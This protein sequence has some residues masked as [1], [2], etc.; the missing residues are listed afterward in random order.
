MTGYKESLATVTT[1]DALIFF[2]PD[3]W[4]KNEVCQSFRFITVLFSL[5]ILWQVSLKY[6]KLIEGLGKYCILHFF[7]TA[8]L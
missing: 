2:H 1:G 6:Q 4:F 3:H 7:T 8:Q 5:R